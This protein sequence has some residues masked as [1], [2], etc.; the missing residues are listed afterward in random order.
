MNVEDD[1]TRDTEN[2]MTYLKERCAKVAISY[3]AA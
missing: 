1:E 2:S 3:Q